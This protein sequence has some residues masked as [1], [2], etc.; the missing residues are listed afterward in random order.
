MRLMKQRHC[1]FYRDVSPPDFG[2]VIVRIST[3][4][5]GFQNPEKPM[6]CFTQDFAK[7]MVI[8]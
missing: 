3:L 5:H 7:A 1:P 2:M 6:N 4:R 8:E